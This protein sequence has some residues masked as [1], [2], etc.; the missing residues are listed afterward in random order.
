MA[1]D[2]EYQYQEESPSQGFTVRSPAA[3]GDTR[4][5]PICGKEMSSRGIGLHMAK[6]HGHQR[7]DGESSRRRGRNVRLDQPPQVNIQ[8]ETDRLVT[9]LAT[10]GTFV[11]PFA[12]HLGLTLISRAGDRELQV[13]NAKP[14]R[15]RG[16]ASVV[17]SYA[18]HDPRIMRGVVRFN[19]IV[20]GSDAIELVASLG[21]AAAVDAHLVDPHL[22]IRLPGVP[23][24]LC[25]RPIEALIGDVVAQVEAM[26]QGMVPEPEAPDAAPD[27]MPDEHAGVFQQTIP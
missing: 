26:G 11:A 14:V 10:I 16:I 22:G 24:E 6:A 23:D 15:K 27:S 1:E 3:E 4:T 8:E 2:Q 20:Q 18:E 21:A 17:M 13:P 7:R 9:S 12:P 5:C 25:P 19:D